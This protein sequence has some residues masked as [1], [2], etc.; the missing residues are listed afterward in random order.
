MGRKNKILNE[1]IVDEVVI[2]KREVGYYSTPTFI[3][4]YITKRVVDIN[5]KG[6]SVFDPCCGKEEMLEPFVEFNIKTYGMDIIR[7]KEKYNCD[8]KNMDFI[9]YYYEFINDEESLSYDYYVLNPPYNCH[10]VRYIKNNKK[11]LKKH[12]KDVGIHNMYGMFISAIIDLAKEG[13]VI[14]II[15]QDSF[16]TS[17]SYIGLREKILKSCAIHEIIM[18]PTDLFIEQGADVRTSIVILQKGLNYQGNIKLKNRFIDKNELIKFLNSSG[19]CD[20]LYS[21]E[22]IILNNKNDNKEFLLECPRDIKC[23]F[24]HNRLGDKFKCITGISTGND[25]RYLSRENKDPHIIPFYKNPGKDR[26][27]TN[28]VMYLDKDFINIS[29]EVSNFIVRNKDLL[30]ESGIICSSM[31]VQFTACRL[32]KNSTFGV[33]TCIICEDKDMFWILAYLNSTLIT[34]LVRGVLIRSNMITSGYVSR[35][36]LLNFDN[37]TKEK[38]NNL[39]SKAYSMIKQR[40][41]MSEVLIEID[42]IINSAAKLSKE[43]IFYINNFKSNLIKRT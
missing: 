13:A 10:E 15:T 29:K 43:T 9:E 34:Y 31:G 8:F 23:L 32:P 27:Y 18:C 26:Y 14:G 6:K 38:L 37:I 28:K 39:G 35:I 16:L 25:E 12:F 30:F 11:T 4:D 21:I 20:N 17:K 42:N 2:D 3:C 1:N 41:D 7:Y 22:D 5:K 40:E 24:N 33:N 36:P 19:H